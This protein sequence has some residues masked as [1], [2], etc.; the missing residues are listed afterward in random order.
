MISFFTIGILVN[1]PGCVEHPPVVAG[2]HHKACNWLDF[3]RIVSQSVAI[4]I[5]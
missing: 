1:C 3:E 4:T 5:Q 2:F